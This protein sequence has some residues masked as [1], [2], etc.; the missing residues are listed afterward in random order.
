[1]MLDVAPGSVGD[2]YFA[3]LP[4]LTWLI[5]RGEKNVTLNGI[6]S[7]IILRDFTGVVLN[8]LFKSFFLN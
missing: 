3:T 8:L 6:V 5:L 7:V 1:M 4:L 2:F